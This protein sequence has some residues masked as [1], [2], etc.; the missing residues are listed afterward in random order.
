MTQPSD[1]HP[2]ALREVRCVDHGHGNSPVAVH[3]RRHVDVL[4]I[5]AGVHSHRARTCEAEVAC[6]GP[7][8]G[9]DAVGVAVEADQGVVAGR[10]L[11]APPLA[12]GC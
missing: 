7:E 9:G 10:V 3:E 2:H 1:I 11:G 5:A 8:A 12:G 6:E 4:G